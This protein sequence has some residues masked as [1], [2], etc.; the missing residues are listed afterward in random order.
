[1]PKLPDITSSARQGLSSSGG[2]V[3]Y[4][5]DFGGAEAKARGLMALGSGLAQ[6]G[7][8]LDREQEKQDHIVAEDAFTQLRARQ[9]DLTAGEESGYDNVR[10]EA[11][12][13]RPLLKEWSDKFA[14]ASSQVGGALQ[15]DRQRELYKQRADI[16]GLQFKEGLLSHLARENKVYSKQVFEGTLDIEQRF[17][18]ANFDQP[19]AVGLSIER[20]RAAVNTQAEAE[21]WPKAYRDAVELKAIG[22][23]HTTVI[24][25]AIVSGNAK[26][27]AEYLKA[28]RDNLTAE[29]LK[30]V[31]SKLK[32]ATDWQAGKGLATQAWA[33]LQAG[34]KPTDVEAWIVEKSTNPQEHA[35]AQSMLTQLQQASDRQD[36]EQRGGIVETFS[37]T[38]TRATMNQ[39]L[40]SDDFLSLKPEQRGAVAEYLRHQ[41]ETNERTRQAERWQSP[42]MFSKFMDT[43]EDPNF[44]T[45]TR[46]D[47]YS[48]APDLGPAMT[49]KLLAEHKA[50]T[51]GIRKFQIDKDII[52]A[53]VPQK[54]LKA[55]SESEKA[56]LKS[57]MGIV[58]S[59]L[60]DWKRDNPGKT[61]S[62]D[63][64][65]AIVRSANKEYVDFSGWYNSTVP[66]YKVTEK[67]KAVPKDFVDGA[68]A[69]AAKN[70]K[71]ITDA[72]IIEKWNATPAK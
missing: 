71:P 27:A 41:V 53:G 19:N 64:Q 2:I 40:Q 39:L 17:V 25:Q 56:Q 22:T 45:K 9:L 10:G 61:P 65:K 66:A 23:L 67:M 38:P 52:G 11:A 21:K 13:K 5:S 70:K 33:R 63:E 12:I 16:A 46:A 49:S 68:R 7:Q 69:W 3:G 36:R 54:L 57:F 47:L 48:L 28:N 30:S 34:E 29:Q 58:E 72:M 8:A 24:D 44:A 37:A 62:L 26:G 60:H 51:E 59:G 1:M 32:P 43:L 55:T 35:A 20:A 18:A 15:N 31:E 14:E 42:Q 6:F 4:Q 50:L